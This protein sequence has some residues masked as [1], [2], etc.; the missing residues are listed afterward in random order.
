MK[1]LEVNLDESLIETKS[2]KGCT[3]Y[4]VNLFEED[5]ENFLEFFGQCKVIQLNSKLV[6]VSYVKN[7]IVEDLSDHFEQ[8]TEC[9][10]H[11]MRY[12]YVTDEDGDVEHLATYILVI[13]ENMNSIDD[14]LL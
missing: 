7:I 8:P 4:I 3:D 1:F 12:I 14:Y 13:D 10:F 5:E 9:L 2:K 11:C 6:R